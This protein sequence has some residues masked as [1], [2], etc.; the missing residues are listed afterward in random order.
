MTI[1][2]QALANVQMW[3]S[4][5]GAG[6]VWHAWHPPPPLS[7]HIAPSSQRGLDRQQGGRY[8][9]EYGIWDLK[10]WAKLGLFGTIFGPFWGFCRYFHEKEEEKMQ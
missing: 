4:G 1:A 5:A 3:D 9:T 7:Q 6:A 8:N 2:R 10:F